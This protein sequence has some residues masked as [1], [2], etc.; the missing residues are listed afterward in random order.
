M[1][2]DTIESYFDHVFG[3]HEMVHSGIQSRAISLDPQYVTADHYAP[4]EYARNLKGLEEFT[5]YSLMA[6]NAIEW[7]ANCQGFWFVDGFPFIQETAKSILERCKRPESYLSLI[8]T[9]IQ[10]KEHGS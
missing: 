4:I 1:E 9:R 10:V 3:H 2:F 8:A 6:Y 5:S 7:Y